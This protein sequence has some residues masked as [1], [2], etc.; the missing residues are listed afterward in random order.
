MPIALNYDGLNSRRPNSRHSWDNPRTGN[1]GDF[2]VQDY[3]NGPRGR[4]C[5]NFSQTI[6]VQGR[7]EEATGRACR[8][9]DGTWAIV[10]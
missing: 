2:Y 6:W 7:P 1:R 5:A 9:A 8:Q 3:Y 4:E 10:N